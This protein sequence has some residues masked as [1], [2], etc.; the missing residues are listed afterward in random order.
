MNRMNY[1]N[2]I[3]EEHFNE[4]QKLNQPE[5]EFL[6]ALILGKHSFCSKLVHSYLAKKISIK[7]LYENIFKKSLYDVGE[8]WEHNK[9]SVATEH[10]ASAIVEAILNQLYF[11]IISN[12]KN[13]KT[14]ICACV[15]NEF[16]QI[17]IKMISDLFEMNS[18]NSHFLGSNVPILELISFIKQKNPDLLAISLSLYFNF[19][20]LEKMIQKVQ[21]EFP[22]LPILVGGQAFQHG[23][24]EIIMKYDNVV[25]QSDLNNTELYIK[26][27]K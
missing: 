5:N 8:L 12:E 20:S 19:P 22:E 27:F 4:S 11:E 24:K 6:N 1:Q 7:E 13:G 14:V 25:F 21:K 9:I 3:I 10:L 15:E 17:G 2:I 16:H 18:W 26:N 23:G